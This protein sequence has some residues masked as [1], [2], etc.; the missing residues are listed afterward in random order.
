MQPHKKYLQFTESH[1][2]QYFLVAIFI[3]QRVFLGT[4]Y[5]ECNRCYLAVWKGRELCQY[6]WVMLVSSVNAFLRML[7]ELT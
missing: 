7:N 6:V 5:P 2:Q 3:S 1:H 4:L